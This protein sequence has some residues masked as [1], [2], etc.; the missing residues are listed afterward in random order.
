MAG[1]YLQ[2]FVAALLLDLWVMAAEPTN[3]GIVRKSG[4]V[5]NQGLEIESFISESIPCL[6][7]SNQKQELSEYCEW[8]T[9][10]KAGSYRKYMAISSLSRFGLMSVV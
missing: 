3:T 8:K 9:M 2:A 10:V 1:V 6:S 5:W 7:V 4:N